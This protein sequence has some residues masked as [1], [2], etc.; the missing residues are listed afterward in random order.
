MIEINGAHGE[1]GGQ[2]IRTSVALSAITGKAVKIINIRSGRPNPGLQAQHLEAVKAV[3]RLCK[4]K[5]DASIGATSLLFEPGHIEGGHVSIDIGTAGAA[6]LVLQAL[7]LPAIHAEHPV[8]LRISGGTHVR[9]SPSMDYMQNIFCY[10]MK[11]LGIDFSIETEKY[12]FYPKGGGIVHVKIAPYVPR[13][14]N[15]V[16]QGKL[17]STDAISL[18]TEDLRKTEVAD[19]Q[20]AGAERFV[21][22]DNRSVRY[23]SALSTGSSIFLQN[24][25]FLLYLQRISLVP[26]NHKTSQLKLLFLL[27]YLGK[28]T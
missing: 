26:P 23:V 8:S 2:I 25:G 22:I 4:G 12:G 3:A 13:P 7:A 5:T 14:L 9:W 18:A 16:E 27:S 24:V 17:V 6:S 15:L 11:K 28:S 21:K 1:G 20:I 19:R 10:Y